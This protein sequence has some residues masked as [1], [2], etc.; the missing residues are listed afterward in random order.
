MPAP[1]K[2]VEKPVE[3]PTEPQE[4]YFF[5]A[6]PVIAVTKIVAPNKV[7]SKE[8]PPRIIEKLKQKYGEDV[9]KHLD[10]A[11]DRAINPLSGK[12]EVYIDGSA[13]FSAMKQELGIQGS[14]LKLPGISIVGVYFPEEAVTVHESHITTENG[15]ETLFVAEVIYPGNQGVLIIRQLKGVEFPAWLKVPTIQIGKTKKR[16]RGILQIKWQ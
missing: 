3:K 7:N 4:Q 12:E 11:F 2:Q 10:V 9:V 15:T 16:G 13:I 6:T 8:F 1:R 5:Y 14:S